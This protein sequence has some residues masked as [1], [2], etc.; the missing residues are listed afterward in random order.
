MVC[1]CVCGSSSS[2][3]KRRATCKKR[4]RENRPLH[5]SDE[6]ACVALLSEL[7]RLSETDERCVSGQNWAISMWPGSKVNPYWFTP[8]SAEQPHRK[9]QQGAE[10]YLAPRPPS[11]RGGTFWTGEGREDEAWFNVNHQLAALTGRDHTPPAGPGEG[12]AYRPA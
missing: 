11:R 7:Q 3:C 9:D 8:P 6:L 4:K 2:R 12:C 5:L 1:V 10:P